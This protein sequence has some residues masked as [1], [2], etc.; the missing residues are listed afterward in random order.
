MT[1]QPAQ[2]KIPVRVQCQGCGDCTICRLAA[3]DPRYRKFVASYPEAADSLPALPPRPAPP[4]APA[5]GPGT[6]LKALLSGLGV[7]A[8]AACSCNA[9]ARQMNLWGVDGCREHRADVVAWLEKRRAKTGWGATIHAYLAGARNVVTG[10]FVPNPA[11]VSG[12]LVDEAIRLAAVK[13]GAVPNVLLVGESAPPAPEQTQQ[14]VIPCP[15][16]DR[17]S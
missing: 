8:T 11:D 4:A 7:K 6:E 9:Y 17:S 2:L 13:C 12:S 15:P 16:S 3:K 5:G 1:D 14:G 10:G